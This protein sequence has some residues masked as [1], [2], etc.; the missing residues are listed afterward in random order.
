VRWTIA[1][2]APPAG[3]S[4]WA[5]LPP[6]SAANSLT[7]VPSGAKASGAAARVFVSKTRMTGSAKIRVTLAAPTRQGK[8]RAGGFLVVR[9][10]CSRGLLAMRKPLC[11]SLDEAR[12]PSS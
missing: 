11:P 6:E 2:E 9:D 1:R 10:A 3:S 5:K 8:R 12:S 4:K 7:A